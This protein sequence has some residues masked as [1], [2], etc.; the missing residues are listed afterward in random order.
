MAMAMCCRC[1]KWV[2]LDWNVEEI[3]YVDN[4]SVCLDCLT[5]EELEKLEAE[6]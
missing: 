4:K 5:D 2:D 1:D 3:E 6:L